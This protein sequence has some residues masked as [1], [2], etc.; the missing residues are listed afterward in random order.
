MSD[1]G[2]EPGTNVNLE[3]DDEDLFPAVGAAKSVAPSAPVSQWI[4]RPAGYLIGRLQII[5][6]EF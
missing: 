1:F 4:I 6:A 3:S 2:D 5:I